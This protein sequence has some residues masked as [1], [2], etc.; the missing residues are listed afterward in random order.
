MALFYNAVDIACYNAYTI[1]MHMN[2]Q[3][4]KGLPHRRRIFLIQLGRE[5]AGVFE[6]DD[7]LAAVLQEQQTKS[8]GRCKLCG[9]E[10]DR[11]SS[12]RCRKCG[13]AMC[14]DHSVFLCAACYDE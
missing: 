3:W 8:R 13:N 10:K 12:L 7:D 6:N 9:W 5:L 14:K 4:N 11:K 2:P 1:F